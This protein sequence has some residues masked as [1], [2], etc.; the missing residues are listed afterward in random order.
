MRRLKI[1]EFSDILS[2]DSFIW[3]I[4][5]KYEPYRTTEH[6]FIGVRLDGKKF[7]KASIFT[8]HLF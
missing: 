7:P 4:L 8:V 2:F 6:C 5:A 3:I 1:S